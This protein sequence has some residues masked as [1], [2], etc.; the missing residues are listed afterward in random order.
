MDFWFAIYISFCQLLILLSSF[1]QFHRCLNVPGCLMRHFPTSF[2]GR[3]PGGGGDLYSQGT[4]TQLTFLLNYRWNI[5]IQISILQQIE[6]AVLFICIS[7]IHVLFIDAQISATT[8]TPCTNRRRQRLVAR[9]VYIPILHCIGQA[10]TLCKFVGR[11]SRAGAHQ[12]KYNQAEK[13]K[14]K[15]EIKVICETELS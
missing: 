12:H 14:Q 3:L 10:L 15:K 5:Y 1:T 13:L 7:S 9:D 11:E 8:A 2:F 4:T 6:T